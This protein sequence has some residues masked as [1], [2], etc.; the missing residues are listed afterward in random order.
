VPTFT[1][2]LS[3]TQLVTSREHGR[4]LGC[5]AVQSG[6]SFQNVLQVSETSSWWWGQYNLWNVGKLT[7]VYTALQPRRRPCLYSS[8]WEPQ[9]MHNSIYWGPETRQNSLQRPWSW[10]VCHRSVSRATAAHWL[11]TSSSSNRHKATRFRAFRCLE[12][13][14]LLF[15]NSAVFSG[16]LPTAARQSKKLVCTHA[17]E[18]AWLLL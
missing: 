10:R 15:Q 12:E 6:T 14:D 3:L 2:K 5:S 18:R 1:E 17:A 16:K 9:I 13:T 8:P 11:L 4:L 7:P